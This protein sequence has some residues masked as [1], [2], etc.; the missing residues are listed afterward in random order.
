M[1]AVFFSSF[2]SDTA[3]STE[4][5]IAIV[6]V[7]VVL[8]EIMVLA[9]VAREKF[10]NIWFAHLAVGSVGGLIMTALASVNGTEMAKLVPV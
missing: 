9:F 6:L 5:L 1:P 10:A 7:E 8:V 3:G 2:F 4:K